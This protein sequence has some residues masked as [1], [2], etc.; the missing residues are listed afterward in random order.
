V[1]FFSFRLV[2]GFMSMSFCLRYTT[3]DVF[4]AV[5]PNKSRF[6]YK[7]VCF[8]WIF[9]CVFVIEWRKKG[10]GTADMEPETTIPRPGGT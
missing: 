10:G 5:I 8:A 1:T 7:K 4:Q 2:F 3:W 6:K 9:E